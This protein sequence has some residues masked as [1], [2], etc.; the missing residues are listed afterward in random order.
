MHKIILKYCFKNFIWTCPLCGL[1][2]REINTEENEKSNL[3]YLKN[4]NHLDENKNKKNLLEYIQKKKKK[5][6]NSIDVCEGK[7]YKKAINMMI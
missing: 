7:K 3:K 5:Y 6:C 4:G 1:Y 2:Y